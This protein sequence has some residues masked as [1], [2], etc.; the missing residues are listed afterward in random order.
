VRYVS[1]T[2]EQIDAEVEKFERAYHKFLDGAGISAQTRLGKIGF[3]LA[4]QKIVLNNP[5]PDADVDAGVRKWLEDVLDVY[6]VGL[7]NTVQ[8]L[9]MNEGWV[10]APE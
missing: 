1:T 2:I 8:D 6:G 7:G 5:Y 4:V 9:L 10:A 3:F